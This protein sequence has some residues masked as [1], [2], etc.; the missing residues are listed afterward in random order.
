VTCGI[1]CR[2][3]TQW[4]SIGIYG[5]Q[6]CFGTPQCQTCDAVFVRN[7]ANM[8]KAESV[9]SDW[10]QWLTKLKCF[11]KFWAKGLHMHRIEQMVAAKAKTL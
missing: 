2:E 3:A 7:A 1:S 4:T 6:R 8:S 5:Y 11:S 10:I 9:R